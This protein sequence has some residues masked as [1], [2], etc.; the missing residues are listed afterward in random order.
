[1]V[2]NA[3]F[4]EVVGEYGGKFGCDIYTSPGTAAGAAGKPTIPLSRTGQAVTFNGWIIFSGAIS[5][6]QP[7]G[8][9]NALGQT[10]AGLGFVGTDI[11]NV[12]A[13]GPGVCDG[14]TVDTF[15]GR[16]NV[17]GSPPFLHMDGPVAS[18]EGC[19]G[20]FSGSP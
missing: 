3:Q 1:M 9:T 13:T 10:Y 14:L 15:Q 5:P 17:D 8:D 2:A 18:R 11:D 7:D 20:H 19:S 16:E 12:R 4:P 6:D